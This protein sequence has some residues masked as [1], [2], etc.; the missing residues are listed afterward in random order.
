MQSSF[1][2][3]KHQQN[4]QKKHEMENQRKMQ[5]RRIPRNCSKKRCKECYRTPWIHWQFVWCLFFLREVF[6]ILVQVSFQRMLFSRRLLWWWTVYCLFLPVVFSLVKEEREEMREKMRE[7]WLWTFPSQGLNKKHCCK[8]WSLKNDMLPQEM[9][10]E[11]ISHPSTK[12][13]PYEAFF[14]SD[15]KSVV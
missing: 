3:R 4:L 5:W 11:R 13:I 14:T 7:V 10:G 8:S 12:F 2:L 15:P 1:L 9:R 6:L